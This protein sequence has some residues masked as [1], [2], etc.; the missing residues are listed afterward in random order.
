MSDPETWRHTSLGEPEAGSATPPSPLA[1]V[2]ELAALILA[3]PASCIAGLLAEH[4]DDGTGHCR[5]CSGGGQSG[6]YRYPCAI[7]IAAEEADA[8]RRSGE[9][10]QG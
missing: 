5:V 4:A 3:Q 7:R 9:A 2:V 6:R 1:L 10:V 8:W